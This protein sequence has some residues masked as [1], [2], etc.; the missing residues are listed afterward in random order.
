MRT[1]ITAMPGPRRSWPTTSA[2]QKA[3]SVSSDSAAAFDHDLG[4]EVVRRGPV[5]GELGRPVLAEEVLQ[6]GEQRDP[7]DRVVLGLH[8][9]LAVVAAQLLQVRDDRLHLVDLADHLDQRPHEAV[10]LGRHRRRGTWAASR[11]G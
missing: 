1:V 8:A 10:A 4:D 2:S 11:G 3:G 9:V 5:G 6:R 7:D